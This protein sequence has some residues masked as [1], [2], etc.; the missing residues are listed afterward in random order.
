MRSLSFTIGLVCLAATAG[1]YELDQSQLDAELAAS[2]GERAAMAGPP[3]AHVSGGGTGAFDP[4]EELD[5][6]TTQFA[7]GAI[8]SDEPTANECDAALDGLGLG[9]FTVTD[10]DFSAATGEFNCSVNFMGEGFAIIIGHVSQ[11]RLNGDGTVTLCGRADVVDLFL[12]EIFLDCPF[13][14]QLEDGD[15]D[16]FVYY[17]IVTGTAGDAETIVNGQINVH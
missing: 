17:D 1:C 16:H 12:G 8:V 10:G 2:G 3:I 4:G 14:V 15:P 5:G 9:D 7:V 13:A 11:G 6:F